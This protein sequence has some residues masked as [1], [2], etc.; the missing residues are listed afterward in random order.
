MRNVVLILLT[1]LMILF[2]SV[3]YTFASNDKVTIVYFYSPTCSTCQKLQSYFDNLQDKY[4]NILLEKY[5]IAVSC[6]KNCPSDI[7]NKTKN[8]NF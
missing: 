5:N 6:Y 2:L 1:T 8:A 7:N 4:T 3:C